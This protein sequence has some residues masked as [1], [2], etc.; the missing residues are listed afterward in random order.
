MPRK[1]GRRVKA[2]PKEW[3]ESFGEKYY[4]SKAKEQSEL[5]SIKKGF[6][7]EQV[8]YM[9]DDEAVTSPQEAA[10][11]IKRILRDIG[12]DDE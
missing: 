9:A 7:G 10:D 4:I 2:Y 1:R 5:E 11:H 3:A 6:E 12:A 8:A